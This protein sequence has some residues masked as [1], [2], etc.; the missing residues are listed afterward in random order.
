[1]CGYIIAITQLFTGDLRYY[2]KGKKNVINARKTQKCESENKLPYF[3]TKNKVH[4]ISR[5]F[6][7][8]EALQRIVKC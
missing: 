7:R 2:Q 8:D 3:R 5:E 6:M 4:Q 1:M